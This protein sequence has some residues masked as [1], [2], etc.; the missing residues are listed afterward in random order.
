MKIVNIKVKIA[1]PKVENIPLTPELPAILAP[2][3]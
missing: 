1:S 2:L 3:K